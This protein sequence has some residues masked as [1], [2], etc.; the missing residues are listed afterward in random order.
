MRRFASIFPTAA[1]QATTLVFDTADPDHRWQMTETKG[2]NNVA[3]RADEVRHSNG[4]GPDRLSR[5]K[6]N[7]RQL[8]PDHR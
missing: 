3:A 4:T 7:A 8:A 1:V 5:H 6:A 2:A